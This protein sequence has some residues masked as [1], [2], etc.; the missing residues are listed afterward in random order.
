VAGN[1]G[2]DLDG[3]V[4]D[5]GED[6]DLDERRLGPLG[7]LPPQLLRHFGEAGERAGRGRRGCGISRHGSLLY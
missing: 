2:D 1:E 6:E 4:Q 3:Q 5:G 7:K